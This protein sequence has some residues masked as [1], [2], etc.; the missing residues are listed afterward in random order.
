[1]KLVDGDHS[2]DSKDAAK[3]DQV[4]KRIIGAKRVDTKNPSLCA[5][6]LTNCSSVEAKK[7]QK[8]KHPRTNKDPQ[9]AQKFK[10]KTGLDSLR[11]PC[12]KE[13]MNY[14]EAVDECYTYELDIDKNSLLFATRL[15]CVWKLLKL[16]ATFRL[17]TETLIL[18]VHLFDSFLM[19]LLEQYQDIKDHKFATSINLRSYVLGSKAADIPI[20]DVLEAAAIAAIF[21]SGK[22]EEID[23]PRLSTLLEF[24]RFDMQTIVEAEHQLLECID[25]KVISPSEESYI[26]WMTS[27]LTFNPKIKSH[28]IK[29]VKIALL[30]NFLR[31]HNPRIITLAIFSYVIDRGYQHLKTSFLGLISWLNVSEQDVLKVSEDFFA[32][33]GI[34][35]EFAT[36]NHL[37]ILVVHLDN[38]NSA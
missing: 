37:D 33:F 14:L 7:R 5:D 4:S 12:Q 2:V 10:T 21:A 13:I 15:K 34:I 31:K 35:S 20:V 36:R 30:F 25:Y 38:P 17:T 1:M 32:D 16:Q 27:K 29:Y 23:P 9:L 24:S 8:K 6:S 22:F 28:I 19:H 11:F 26:N 3:N 18:A